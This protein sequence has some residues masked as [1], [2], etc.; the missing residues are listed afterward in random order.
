MMTPVTKRINE[1]LCE[2]L[3]RLIWLEKITESALAFVEANK[4][5]KLTERY[6]KAMDII[7]E[8]NVVCK[9]LIKKT[10]LLLDEK[11]ES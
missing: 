9:S 10:R 3:N 1:T 4:S 11:K 5:E 2:N 6:K 8:S 7:I